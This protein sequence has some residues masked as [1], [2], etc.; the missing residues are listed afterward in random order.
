MRRHALTV[1]LAAALIIAGICGAASAGDKEKKGP[2]FDGKRGGP[3]MQMMEGMSGGMGMGAPGAMDIEF[4]LW[5]ADKLSDAVDEAMGLEI[6][7]ALNLDAKQKAQLKEQIEK[8]KKIRE[9]AKSLLNEYEGKLLPL[10]NDAKS[11]IKATGMESDKTRGEMDKL[12]RA[13]RD[14]VKPLREES[15]DA[16][17]KIHDVFKKEQIDKLWRI[18]PLWA[19]VSPDANEMEVHPVALAFLDRLRIMPGS[20]LD[21]IKGKIKDRMEKPGFPLTKKQSDD[22][23]A[24]VDK[25][26]ALSSDEYESQRETLASG[27]D[28]AIVLL[29]NKRHHGAGGGMGPDK[30]SKSDGDEGPDKDDE[31]DPPPFVKH[32]AMKHF[33]HVITGDYFYSLIK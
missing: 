22:F 15:F 3:R 13:Y 12:V 32:M 10:V 20:K 11:E 33:L 29:V 19:K 6:Y 30:I 1:A 9:K 31:A 14:A 25:I 8:V 28:P 7:G 2:K 26:R 5:R 23:F 27:L 17:K 24:M 4:G 16:M 21:Q 18:K